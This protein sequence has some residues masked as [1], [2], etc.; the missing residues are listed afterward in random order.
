M[1]DSAQANLPVTTPAKFRPPPKA[2]ECHAHVFGPFS[3]WPTGRPTSEQPYEAYVRMHEILGI[4]RGVL[5]QP[6]HY[7]VDN[8]CMLDAMARSN[9][10]VKGI[11]ATE[12]ETLTDK[13][14]LRLDALGVRGIRIGR[15]APVGLKLDDLEAA[16]ERLKGSGW[17]FEIPPPAGFNLADLRKRIEKLPIPVLFEMLGSPDVKKG[18]EQPSFQALLGMMRD[19]LVWVKLSH[20]YQLA[21]YPYKETIPF[22]Q[23]LVDANPRRCVF[24]TDWPHPG[25]QHEPPVPDD[26]YLLDLLAEWV[27]DRATRDRI[28]VDNPAE[29]HRF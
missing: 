27:P 14:I 15:R 28:L 7:G 29:I 18:L 16:A 6:S 4:E 13:E 19:N 11:I 12:L 20:P 5:T 17:H 10:N 25:P 8:S 2:A 23:A 22:A 3:K 1:S 21:P 9:G 26:G 24:G